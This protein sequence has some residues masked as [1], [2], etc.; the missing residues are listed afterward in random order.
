MEFN[1]TFNNISV[2]S[3]RCFIGERNRSTRWKPF[4]NRRNKIDAPNTHIH[5]H[6]LFWLS[7][8]IFI[9]SGGVKLILW[10]QTSP[11]SEMMRSWKCFS[12][13]DF[14]I[15]CGFWKT[16]KIF[17][18]TWNQDLSLRYPPSQ[19]LIFQLYIPPYRM[20]N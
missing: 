20:T 17:W 2:I 4:W 11:I 9:K 8:C 18:I 13:M 12:H 14:E 7:T 15:T 5:D 3:W 1:A 10:L 19:P 16:L 6:S